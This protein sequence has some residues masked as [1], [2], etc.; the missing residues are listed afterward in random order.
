MFT[1]I[2]PALFRGHRMVQLSDTH[3]TLTSNNLDRLKPLRF[4]IQEDSVGQ[5]ETVSYNLSE[6]TSKDSV[7]NSSDTEIDSDN[8]DNITNSTNLFL[9]DLDNRFSGKIS[10]DE[11][12]RMSIEIN[13]NI[14]RSFI[15]IHYYN[16]QGQF[17]P[18]R[19][20]RMDE[21]I[22]KIKDVSVDQSKSIKFVMQDSRVGQF[23]TQDY[24]ISEL[25]SSNTSNNTSQD[26]AQ[27]ING[28]AL[29][30]SLDRFSGKITTD[31]NGN[32]NVVIKSDIF[33]KFVDIHYFDKSGHFIPM[34]MKQLADSSWVV[35]KKGID[36]NQPIKFVIQD[37]QLGQVVTEELVMQHM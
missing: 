23:V 22:W 20:V 3:W 5:Y 10:L 16:A 6:L 27:I 24:F 35:E 7:D 13:G 1:E 29:V 15:D 11:N 17:T 4:V 25:N 9:V 32:S 28:I 31:D 14:P 36:L 2:N 21:L 12:N 33:R 19:M 8:S 30:D 26:S 37:D 34:R 18:R